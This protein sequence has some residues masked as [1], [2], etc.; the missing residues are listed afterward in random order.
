MV[1][2]DLSGGQQFSTDLNEVREEIKQTS[3]EEHLRHKKHRCAE[4]RT[5]MAC[6]RNSKEA[7]MAGGH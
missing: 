7:R 3:R 2:E 4:E 1:M 5:Y 6:L